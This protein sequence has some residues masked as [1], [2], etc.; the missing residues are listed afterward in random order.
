[1][2]IDPLTPP[3]Q[4]PF[5]CTRQNVNPVTSTRLPRRISE[6]RIYHTNNIIRLYVSFTVACNE[7][8]AVDVRYRH[9]VYKPAYHILCYRWFSRTKHK[10][11]RG[12]KRL[13]NHGHR[14]NFVVYITITR[15][16]DRRPQKPFWEPT[17]SHL[18]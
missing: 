17:I 12:I 15:R 7:N 18:A 9:R 6:S 8:N 3:S 16:Y 4:I 11:Y 14:S 1:M 10:M 13:W 2:F 5:P